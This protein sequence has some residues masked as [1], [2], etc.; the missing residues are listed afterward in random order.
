MVVGPLAGGTDRMAT[1]SAVGSVR[2]QVNARVDGS[3]GTGMLPGWTL[4]ALAQEA[5]RIVITLR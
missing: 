3:V 1:D 2:L 4:G 5:Y